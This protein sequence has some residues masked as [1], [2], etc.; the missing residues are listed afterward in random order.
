[1]CAKVIDLF[2]KKKEEEA[3]KKKDENTVREIKESLDN[4]AVKRKYKLKTPP[5]KPAPTEEERIANVRASVDRINKL[6]NELAEINKK[7]EDK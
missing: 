6:M 4:E 3:K 5:P 1:M 2:K 7:K